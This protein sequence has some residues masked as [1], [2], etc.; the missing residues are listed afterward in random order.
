[1]RDEF[2]QWA[3]KNVG[4]P[5]FAGKHIRGG[6]WSYNHNIMQL[7]WECWQAASRCDEGR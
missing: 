7:C 2:E 1:M 6:G 3:R 4:Q 5:S